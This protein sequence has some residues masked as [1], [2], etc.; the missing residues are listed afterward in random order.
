MTGEATA[1]WH[2]FATANPQLAAFGANRLVGRVAYLA[3]AG[4]GGAPRLHPVTAHIIAGG[5]FVYMEPASP[6]VRD[7]RHDGRY[8]LHCSVEDTSGGGGEFSIRGRAILI[9]DLKK[10]AAVFETA[11][12]QGSNPK[13]RYVLF[14]LRIETA[15][16]TTYIDGVPRR[17]IWK[18]FSL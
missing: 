2:D 16:S 13:D 5:C 4:V 3:T 8:A 15:L 17:E 7:L 12:A 6:K 1:T 14:A 18:A 9:E 11:K 10:R